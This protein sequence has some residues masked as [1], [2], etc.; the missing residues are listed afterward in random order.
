VEIGIDL[1]RFAI[2][3]PFPG[4][5]LYQRL[6]AQGRILTRDWERYDGQHAVFQPVHMSPQE[7]EQAT[8]A[9]WRHAYSWP[10]ILRRL[11]RTAAPMPVAWITNL[12]YRHYA[13]N[14]SRFYTCDW[15]GALD[16]FADFAPRPST[17]STAASTAS[18][19]AGGPA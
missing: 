15:A 9:A 10:S 12:G 5:P 6:E 19:T 3:T 14:L 16:P 7:L 13:R 4:T 11:R 1:P 2:A 8:G 18:S 17:R